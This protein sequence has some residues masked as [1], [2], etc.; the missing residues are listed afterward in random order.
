MELREVWDQGLPSQ[1]CRGSVLE[2]R[3]WRLCLVVWIGGSDLLSGSRDDMASVPELYEPSEPQKGPEPCTLHTPTPA[4]LN[5]PLNSECTMW[6]IRRVWVWRVLGLTPKAEDPS[7][8]PNRRH[9]GT[10]RI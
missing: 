4:V 9:R 5:K 6:P 3:S 1:G 7:Q 8:N 2:F 10:Q